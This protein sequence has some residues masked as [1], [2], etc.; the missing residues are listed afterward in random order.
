MPREPYTLILSGEA[1]A[2]GW[3][4]KP[5]Q[6][7]PSNHYFPTSHAVL[8]W[9][10]KQQRPVWI[11]YPKAFVAHD[12]YASRTSPPTSVFTECEF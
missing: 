9:K 5:N 4:K 3:K 2:F 1:G 11:S 6:P 12:T 7:R 10:S 8:V